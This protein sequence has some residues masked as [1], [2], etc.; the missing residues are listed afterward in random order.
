[1][2]KSNEYELLLEKLE[3]AGFEAYIVG[4]C[5]R[6]KLLGNE[7]NDFD[8]TTNALPEETMAVF[9]DLK[10]VPTG[11]KHGTV[12]VIY[13]GTH[14]EITTF[15]VDGSYTDSRRP[16]SVRFTKSLEEDLARRDFTINAIAM[17]LRGTL[18]DPFGGRDDIDKHIIRCVGDPDKR[19][20]E[21]ALRI[22]RAV[23]F[24][25][26]LG[27]EIEE[28][29]S[30]SALKLRSLLD[31]ISRE[32]CRDELSK[33]IMGINFTDT[34]LRY[35]DIIAQIIPEF[36][37]CFDFDQHSKYHKY[38]VYEHI[39]RTVAAAPDDPILKTAMLFHDISKPSMFRLDENGA[40][41]FKGHAH[42]S[43][44]SANEIMRRLHFEN[45]EIAD[46]CAIIDHHSDKIVSEQQIKRL[47]PQLGEEN[48]FRLMDAKKADNYAKHEFVLVENEWFDKCADT[49]RRFIQDGT[50][51]SLSQLAVDGN[52]IIDLG[53]EGK[54]IGYCLNTLLDLVIDDKIPN[55][56]DALLFHAKELLI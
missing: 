2:K 38:T 36:R 39:I 8:I 42:A 26:T 28:N 24:S 16:D 33:M 20:T 19:F 34:A 15:R 18:H 46:A 55:E 47:I 1:M 25:S 35:R 50:C 56:R 6:D 52:D 45:D 44:E 10:V 4:G 41:H 43:A 49:A 29:T 40:G 22:M 3:S 5:V 12:T 31:N 9:S 30:S 11:L 7:I 21:D 13:N 37:A 23:R 14:F 48:F 54:Q 32:R 51:I 53:G 17:D 27:F